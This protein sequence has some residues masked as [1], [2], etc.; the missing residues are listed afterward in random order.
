MYTRR[1]SHSGMEIVSK[2]KAHNKNVNSRNITNN[3]NVNSLIKI[4]KER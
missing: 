1:N 3:S 4:N 2:N